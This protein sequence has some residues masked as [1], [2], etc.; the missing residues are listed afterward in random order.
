MATTTPRK[1]A[2]KKAPAKKAAPS[3][4]IDQDRAEVLLGAGYKASPAPGV[5]VPEEFR[6]STDSGSR[7]DPE[8]IAIELDGTACY[9]SQ[10]SDALI[11][12]LGSAFAPMAD[13][14]EKLGAM[15][16]LVNTSLDSQGTAILRRAMFA[17]DNSF[18]DEL[19]GHLT[20]IILDKWAPNVSADADLTIRNQNRA[21]RRAK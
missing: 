7:R 3:T 20:A 18:D 19:L 15:L 11:A 12:L 1:T 2:A 9:L 5:D 13:V 14:T 10:P 21:Q 16:N 6:F 4:A 17:S 8:R